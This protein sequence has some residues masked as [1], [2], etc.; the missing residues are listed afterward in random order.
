MEM[1]TY[2]PRMVDEKL[3]RRL[4]KFPAVMISG[5]RMVGKT[6]T[7]TQHAKSMVDL[8]NTDM[9]RAF[10]HNA[11]DALSRF[12]EP[13]LI[14]EWQTVPEVMSAIKGSVDERWH[15]NRFI[16][17][18]SV[19]A[20]LKKGVVGGAGRVRMI[21]MHPMTVAEIKQTYSKPLVDRIVEG[22]DLGEL[23]WEWLEI[24]E[25]LD[26]AFR[27][28]F[29]SAQRVAHEDLLEF[30]QDNLDILLQQDLSQLFDT[31]PDPDGLYNYF[32]SYA[33]HTATLAHDQTIYQAVNISRP[34]AEVY[35]RILRRLLVIKEVEAWHTDIIPRLRRQKKRFVIDPSLYAAVVNQPPNRI[36]L[37]AR[38]LG[39][40]L[41][42]FVAAQIRAELPHSRYHPELYH[43]RDQNGRREVDLLI[44]TSEGVIGIEIKAS[45][46]VG[47]SATDHLKYLQEKLGKDFVAGV[48]LFT[49]RLPILFS[50]TIK[51]YPISVLWAKPKQPD[52]KTPKLP[53]G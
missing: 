52:Q 48:I 26:L 29:P 23:D 13:V 51:A 46:G 47:E 43:L 44:E 32:R 27:G 12:E 38:V 7:A 16:L 31:V 9:A 28:G 39:R 30:H 6:T 1:D 41:E 40:M 19:D 2:L 45:S 25:Y 34:T 22:E 37:N 18:G 3:A 10:R 42:T 4:A 50:E 8:T 17:T 11:H 33:E 21:R 36:R 5:P 14:D 20:R 35:H 24:R 15:P 49:G 53:Y